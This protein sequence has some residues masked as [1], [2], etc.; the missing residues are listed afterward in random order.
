M[1]DRTSST[2]PAG[3][4][5]G[6]GRESNAA[7]PGREDRVMSEEPE[8]TVRRALGYARR[9]WPVFPCRPGGKEPATRHGFHDAS[10]SP[11]QIRS[12]WRC[13][14]AANVAIATGRPG[15]DVLDV[16][17]HGDAGNGFVALGR[18]KSA[19]LLDTVSAV[20]AT[21]G[22]GLHA[23]FTGS[24]QASGRLPRQHLDFRS[25]GG[26]VL[27]PPSQIDGRPY[28]LIGHGAQSGGLDWAAVT[29]LLDPGRTR[30]ARP[31]TAAPGDLTHLAA[32]VERLQEGNRNA[33]LFWAACRAV[34]AGQP[35]VLDD[36]AHAAA[37]T[38]LTGREIARTINSAR[39]GS[40]R[41]FE[42]QTEREAAQ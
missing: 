2:A 25:R 7:D 33:G 27:A 18:L 36:L 17:E 4:A 11:D 9:G 24:D 31:R 39:R 16:D 35:A 32:W 26:Y 34:E 38:G 37:A 15:P 42:R 6:A 8:S 10:T 12:W 3:L 28:R 29:S 23:Y 13:Q 1:S 20:I 5:A 21:P 30:L 41:P 22:G 19:G 40:H 14:P